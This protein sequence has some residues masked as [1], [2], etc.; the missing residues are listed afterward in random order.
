MADETIY[1]PLAEGHIRLLSLEWPAEDD[2]P[3]G[4]LIDVSLAENPSYEALSYAWGECEASIPFSCDG[5]VILVTPNLNAALHRLVARG[6]SRILWIDQICINQRDDEE[7][8]DVS[9]KSEKSVQVAMM[10]D[11]Y[12]TAQ[13]VVVWLGEGSGDI[14]QAVQAMPAIEEALANAGG[15][16]MLLSKANFAHWGLPELDSPIWAALYKIVGSPWFE[17]LGPSKKSSLHNALKFCVAKRLF[18]GIRYAHSQK[19]L[20]MPA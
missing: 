15:G 4:S 16:I 3:L 10:H 6:A 1:T 13:N 8:R 14:E 19:Q 9:E 12:Q 11:I 5:L 17:R 20:G 18:L 2:H 7:R